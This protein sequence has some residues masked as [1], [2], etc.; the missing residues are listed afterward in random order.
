METTYFLGI[1]VAKKTFEA[2]LTIDGKSFYGQSVEN[3]PKEIQL[4]FVQLQEKFKYSSTQLVVCME[5]T[6][7][8]GLPLLDYLV[9]KGIKVCVESGLH[10]LLSQGMK[11]GKN[12]KVDAER[13]AVYAFKNHCELRF[14]TPQRDSI[15]KLKSLLTTRERLITVKIQLETPLK[16]A[17]GYVDVSIR[18]NAA[19]N[20]KEAVDAIK[21]CI[22][23][24]DK[25]IR[26]LIKADQQLNDQVQ[27]VTSVP[28]I[29]MITA[30]NVIV[31]TGEFNKIDQPKKL[32]CFAGV[33][34][35][36]NSSGT[37]RRNR[38]RVSKMAN[39]N[40]KR[41]LHLGA[42]SAIKSKGEIR[43]YYLRRVAEG[44]NKMWTLNAVRNKLITRM[45]ACI[46]NQRPYQ[47]EYTNALA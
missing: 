4:Y 41:L 16:E 8:Y 37:S 13:I 19:K 22:K 17:S 38:P 6:G 14:W 15:Q 30:L 43:D 9:S 36:G 47:K 12:D 32:A 21:K 23:K 31:I 27:L 34:P 5:H 20:C 1:D 42:M 28:G 45:Y 25:D 3:Q 2:A 18:R 46:T 40:L 26:M 39:M 44:K 7:I 33:A 11:R 35:F 29:G 24:V 10:I